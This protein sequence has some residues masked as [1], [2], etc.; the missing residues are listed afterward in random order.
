MRSLKIPE[1]A[2]ADL[3]GEQRIFERLASGEVTER[4]ESK[5]SVTS[6]RLCSDTYSESYYLRLVDAS[7]L[8]IGR[9]HCIW[10][11]LA[12]VIARWPSAL[13]VDGV[14]YYRVSHQ[15]RPP[16]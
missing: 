4:L 6:A 3:F 9:V 13:M 10:C 7:G 12:G 11:P 5:T 1:Y 8:M 15:Q 2:L 16:S 14:T